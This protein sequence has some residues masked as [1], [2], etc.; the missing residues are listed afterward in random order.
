MK[1]IQNF[2]PTKTYKI[3]VMY[4]KYT[5]TISSVCIESVR[6]HFLAVAKLLLF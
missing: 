3:T 2:H 4:K 6:V 1:I 5:C